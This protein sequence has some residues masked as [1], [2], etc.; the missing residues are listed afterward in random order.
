MEV[1]HS[2]L[3]HN[4]AL[5]ARLLALLSKQWSAM[6]SAPGLC[7]GGGGEEREREEK[8]PAAARTWRGRTLVLGAMAPVA[9]C[10]L[11]SLAAEFLAPYPVPA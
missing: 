6:S 2:R 5:Q 8:P 4:K 3:Q 7:V 1:A 10:L 11:E 9:Y